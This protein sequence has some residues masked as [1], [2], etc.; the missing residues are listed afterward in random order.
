MIFKYCKKHAVLI[1]V[2][3]TF[4]AFSRLEGGW[5]HSVSN[6]CDGNYTK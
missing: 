5:L 1:T 6:F 3:D 2:Y 4:S